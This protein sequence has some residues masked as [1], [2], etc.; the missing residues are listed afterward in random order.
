MP[1]H[2]DIHRGNEDRRLVGREQQGRGEV[3]R[4]AVRALRHEIGGRRSDHDEVRC[5]RELDVTHFRLVGQRKEIVVDLSPA[6]TG[7][8]KRRD[9]LLR[10]FRQDGRHNRATLAQSSYQLE[11]LVRRDASA[12]DQEHMFS[13]EMR[14]ST[15]RDS[16]QKGDNSG[17]GKQP[18][19]N[20][21]PA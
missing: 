14:H 10:R 13:G 9:E 2:A 3:V 19:R 15:P 16:A 11:R 20:G 4:Q 21:L 18:E 7:D 17:C 6:E 1:P 12:D 8:G 5:A